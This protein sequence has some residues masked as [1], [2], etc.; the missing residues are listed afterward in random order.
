[1]VNLTQ[2]SPNWMPADFS[3]YFRGSHG[4]IDPYVEFFSHIYASNTM[5]QYIIYGWDGADE[6]AL[7]RRMSVRPLHF[8]SARRLKEAG[9]FIFGGAMLDEE[10][11]M[12]GSCMVMQFETAEELQQW[13]DTEP[14][15]T[16]RVWEKFE[17]RPFKVAEV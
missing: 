14:Y 17:C 10:G 8:A 7:E 9:H 6:Q 16:G 13:L 4:K 12:I 1:M 15:I 2:S 11:K 5:K 3:R